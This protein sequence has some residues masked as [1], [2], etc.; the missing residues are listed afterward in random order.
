MEKVILLMI[1]VTI[2]V[3]LVIISTHPSEVNN[4]SSIFSKDDDMCQYGPAYWCSSPDA[5][6][7][8]I[9]EGTFESECLPTPSKPYNT[10]VDNRQV[11]LEG[12]K[13]WCSGEKA[14]DTCV[15]STGYKGNMEQFCY[16]ARRYM[17]E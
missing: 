7:S 17:A 5:F 12:P 2:I 6:Q 3:I 14:F 16:N 9:D 1:V 4:F 10:D 8:C 13:Y 11:C 15:R